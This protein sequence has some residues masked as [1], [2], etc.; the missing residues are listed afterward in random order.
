[1]QINK[2]E[3]TAKVTLISDESDPFYLRPYLGYYLINE[4]L[5]E[6]QKLADE[7]LRELRGVDFKLGVKVTRILPRENAIELSDGQTLNYNFLLIATGT[8]FWS[9]EIAPAG[10]QA[11]TLKTKADA[12]RLRREA[13]RADSVLVYGGGYQALE[14]CRVFHLKEKQVRWLAP[15]GFFWPNQLPGVTAEEVKKKLDEL[16][17]DVKINRRIVQ[18][19]DMDGER[20]RVRDDAGETFDC[21]LLVLAPHEAPRIDFLVGSGIHLDRGILVNEEL[22]TNIPNI[23]AAGDCAQVYDINSGQSVINFGWKSAA[24]QGIVAGENISGRNSVV[25]PTQNE[26]ILDLMGKRLLERW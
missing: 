9:Q 19:L 18:V 2:L 22:R 3:P 21:D 17:L 20:Y 13:E 4:K 25:I 24:K 16:G 26:F 8:Q 14:L 6:A 10:A 7:D 12:L 23:L 15:P 5:P 11:F 1:M